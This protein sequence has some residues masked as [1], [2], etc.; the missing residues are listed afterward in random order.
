MNKQPLKDSIADLFDDVH[1]SPEE[2]ATL[3]ALEHENDV[4]KMPRRRFLALAAGVSAVAVTGAVSWRLNQS[5]VGTLDAL[6]NEIA[7]NHLE[8]HPV[9]FQAQSIAELRESFARQGF[10]V[11]ESEP[12]K[13]MA[14]RMEGAHFCWLMKQA[15]AE[16]RYRLDDGSHATVLQTPYKPKVFGRL[17]DIGRGER[18]LL[19]YVRGIACQVWCDHDMVYTQARPA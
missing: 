10:L 5:E 19:R 12:L 7:D 13:D 16:F 14:G 15:A 11:N 18:P 2:L 6:F 4:P 1:L 17:P 9:V 8:G 3:H